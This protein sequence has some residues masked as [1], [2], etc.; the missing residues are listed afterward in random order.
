MSIFFGISVADQ[1]E[2]SRY[3]EDKKDANIIPP[4]DFAKG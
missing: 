2:E 1:S 3:T 4:F